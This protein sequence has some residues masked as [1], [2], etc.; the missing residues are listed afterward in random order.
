[1]AIVGGALVPLATGALADAT[2]IA[3]SLLIPVACYVVIAAFGLT[4]T[5]PVPTAKRHQA[6]ASSGD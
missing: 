3:T 2:S 6:Y 4:A 5:K 1:M